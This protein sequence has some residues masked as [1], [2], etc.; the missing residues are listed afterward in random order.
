M[1][2][3]LIIH[4]KRNQTSIFIG[5]FERRKRRSICKTQ[6]PRKQVRQTCP[7]APTPKFNS[8][9]ELQRYQQPAGESTGNNATSQVFLEIPI[10]YNH[11]AL[12]QPWMVHTGSPPK[13]PAKPKAQ[14]P[15]AVLPPLSQS[16]HKLS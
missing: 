16:G 4:F 10:L 7:S 2:N 1:C 8:A 12:L 15:S 6:Q 14:D 5:N 11:L 13:A 3:A 9:F